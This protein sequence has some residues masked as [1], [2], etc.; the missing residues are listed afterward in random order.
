[1]TEVV[2]RELTDEE[3]EKLFV[4]ESEILALKSTVRGSGT[5]HATDLLRKSHYEMMKLRHKIITSTPDVSD[6]EYIT[7]DFDR[8]TV[9][10]ED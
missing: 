6:Y 9:V 3:L 7:I 4:L 2:L 1:M 10:G 5:S 8:G